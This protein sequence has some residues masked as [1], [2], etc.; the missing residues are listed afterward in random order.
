MTKFYSIYDSRGYVINDLCQTNVS[1]LT[2]SSVR[3]E[4]FVKFL[5]LTTSMTSMSVIKLAYVPWRYLEMKKKS[6]TSFLAF[7][8]MQL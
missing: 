2:L 3:G 5:E 4:R 7:K 1:L 6:Y 8:K